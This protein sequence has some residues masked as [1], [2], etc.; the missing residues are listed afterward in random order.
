MET[1]TVTELN[2]TPVEAQ[3]TTAAAAKDALALQ[4]A[5]QA[6]VDAAQCENGKTA[7]RNQ[8]EIIIAGCHATTHQDR[9]D[10]RQLS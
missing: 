2:G 7:A 5:L 9:A 8:L 1:V 6:G 4:A 10:S 3:M